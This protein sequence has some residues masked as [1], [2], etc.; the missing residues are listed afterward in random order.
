MDNYKKDREHYNNWKDFGLYG[1]GSNFFVGNLACNNYFGKTNQFIEDAKS[2][3]LSASEFDQLANRFIEAN[4]GIM[5]QSLI[6]YSLSLI[7][8]GISV[9]SGRKMRKV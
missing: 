1:F 6:N 5:E 9:Y 7:C 4:F 8:L 2:L 3:E